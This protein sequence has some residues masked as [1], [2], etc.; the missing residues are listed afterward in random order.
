[1]NDDFCYALKG[2]KVRKLH[3]SRRDAFK[4]VNC[5]PI[6]RITEDKIE[7][8][9]EHKIRNNKQKTKLD[10]FYEKKVA[11]IKVY[12]GQSPNI[13]NY[14]INK[15]YKGIILEMFGLGH[16]PATTSRDAWIK[17]LKYAQKKGIIICATSQTIY[18]RRSEERRVGKE[19]RSRWSPYH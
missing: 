14:Y 5:K 1:M 7:K 4:P 17:K 18:G 15:N 2:T 6:A 9:S 13:L 10:I 3:S 16:V 8:I 11:L 19:C 12:P